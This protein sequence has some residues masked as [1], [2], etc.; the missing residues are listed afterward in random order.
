MEPRSLQFISTACAGEQAGGSSETLV[1]RVSTDSRQIQPGDL[2]VA[3]PGERFDG[4]DFLIEVANK[5]AAG[6][7]IERNRKRPDLD[8]CPMI[9][10]DNT[11]VPSAASPLPIAKI[12]ALPI[13]AVG[14]SNG[15]TTTKELLA[16]VLKQKLPTLSSE[17]SFNNDIGVPLTLLKLDK[18]H[19]AAVVEVGTNHPGEIANLVGMV[20]PTY[21]VITSIG[22]EHLE[23]FGDPR[24]RR[25][26]G[27]LAR[28]TPSRRWKTFH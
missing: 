27:R 13:V 19:K 5:G 28:G 4:H 23:F 3:L 18:T 15:K 24:R 6:V 26:G 17:A 16:S 9:L 1:Q 2:F 7:M 20:T 25:P 21:G 8:V 11:A 10:V 22:R 14:G 12:F